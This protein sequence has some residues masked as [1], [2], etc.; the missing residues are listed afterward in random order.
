MK[1]LATLISALLFLI[2]GVS[3]VW[4]LPNCP[5]SESLYW[6][7]C[8][9][10]YTDNNGNEYKG[11]WQNGKYHGQGR[12]HYLDGW[13]YRGEFQNGLRHGQGTFSL[14]Y[15]GYRYRGEWQNDKKHGQGIDIGKYGN[16]YV[17]EWQNGKE[18]G[19]GTFI[20]GFRPGYSYKGKFVNGV[21]HGQGTANYPNGDK[22]VG[23][24]QNGRQTGQ[25][26]YTFVNGSQYVGEYKD[27][28]LKG[29]RHG[30]GTYTDADG[31]K[32]RGSWANDS[33]LY[34]EKTKFDYIGYCNSTTYQSIDFPNFCT[35]VFTKG[36]SKELSTYFVQERDSNCSEELEPGSKRGISNICLKYKFYLAYA[37]IGEKLKVNILDVGFTGAGTLTKFF[38]LNNGLIWMI[39]DPNKMIGSRVGD[40]L[41][42]EK[43]GMPENRCSSASALSHNG[44]MWKLY[45]TRTKEH[46]K[47]R[48]GF[49]FSLKSCGGDG[50]FHHG[51]NYW[52][53]EPPSW[54]VVR[55]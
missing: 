37:P 45:N 46:T 39:F 14:E 20:S 51:P 3:H 19:Q 21:F 54:L 28:F 2:V 16:K 47:N 12:I 32:W 24:F 31:H 26:T 53:S 11:A 15:S 1:K 8:K 9:G 48:L 13:K 49:G 44:F 10:I 35:R 30:Y 42:L 17:G 6:N 29:E 18:H 41:I 4:A 36:Y 7:N 50:A 25:G 55:G 38:S 5:S 52:S 33:L 43:I 23:E 27:G 22:Y 40:E 34:L